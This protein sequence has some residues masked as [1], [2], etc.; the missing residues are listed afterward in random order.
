MIA[1]DIGNTFTRMVAFSGST[2]RGRRSFHT[3]DLDLDELEVALLE[4]AE[5]T[6]YRAVWIASVYPPANATVAAVAER[7]CIARTFI[8]SA[9][10]FIMAHSLATPQTTGVD[11]LLSAFAA[12]KM[13]MAG[14]EG[15]RGYVVAQCGSAATID[16]VDAEGVF[17]G[18]FIIP[19]PSLWL[20]GLSTAAMLPDLSS[21]L[22]DWNAVL[23]GDNTRDALLN[24]M[25]LCL[26]TAVA[27]A[28][29]MVSAGDNIPSNGE[30]PLPLVL[31]GGWGNAVSPYVGA[32][33]VYDQD[34]MLHGIRLFAERYI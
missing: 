30:P 6:D 29:M 19:G 11:R 23:P 25:H 10:D 20:S 15:K 34:L 21:E 14:D 5:L 12:G 33:H 13:H 16:Y 7:C 24:G 4:L 3:R 1:V 9:S 28:A 31:T 26:P 32:K 2:I 17:Q 18:G 22:P 27:T 8:R